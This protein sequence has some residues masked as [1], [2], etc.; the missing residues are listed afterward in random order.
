MSSCSELSLPRAG[1]SLRLCLCVRVCA[2]VCV[3]LRLTD[4]LLCLAKGK[5]SGWRSYREQPPL[6]GGGE[7]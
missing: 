7:W 2:C 5:E 3:C 4:L 1:T 6:W